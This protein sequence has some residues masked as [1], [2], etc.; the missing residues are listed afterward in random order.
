[1]L[2]QGGDLDPRRQGFR[3]RHNDPRGRRDMRRLFRPADEQQAAAETITARGSQDRL[4]FRHTCDLGE[5]RPAIRVSSGQLADLLVNPAGGGYGQVPLVLA[6]YRVE[7]L[8]FAEENAFLDGI[9]RERQ[10]GRQGRPDERRGG[11]R[12]LVAKPSFR[13]TRAQQQHGLRASQSPCVLQLPDLVRQFGEQRRAETHRFRATV[14]PLVLQVLS[15]NRRRQN[16][17]GRI[18]LILLLVESLDCRFQTIIQTKHRIANALIQACLVESPF[19]LAPE[20][21]SKGTE[22][23]IGFVDDLDIA[24]SR[25]HDQHEIFGHGPT[26]V[27]N[28]PFDD[29]IV[30]HAEI[31]WRFHPLAGGRLTNF[32]FF[33]R[34]TEDLEKACPPKNEICKPD[35]LLRGNRDVLSVT[36]ARGRFPGRAM[37]CTSFWPSVAMDAKPFGTTRRPKSTKRGLTAVGMALNLPV[38][39]AR[40]ALLLPF[41]VQIL[42]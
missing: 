4:R 35:P 39:C 5:D 22:K 15:R 14:D 34:R 8:V 13:A 41:S 10:R 38:D 19:V 32:N 27:T 24:V 9:F 26:P 25:G 23:A 29:V 42:Q 18:V 7:L 30:T 36:V 21:E 12:F 2:D 6:V 16:V 33:G 17:R 40:A 37:N 31:I 1:M 28:G 3:R 11:D 20:T